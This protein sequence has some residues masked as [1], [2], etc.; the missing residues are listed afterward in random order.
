M[1]SFPWNALRH[2]LLEIAYLQYNQARKKLKYFAKMSHTKRR[3]IYIKCHLER[4]RYPLEKHETS[5]SYCN[6]E[7]KMDYIADGSRAY[8]NGLGKC[9]LS[10]HRLC[11][12]LMFVVSELS[13]SNWRICRYD[14]Q[15][16]R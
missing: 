10:H 4:Q 9:F 8:T 11:F 12:L 14:D 2:Q 5:S 7:N 15:F 13:P 3:C 16:T 6:T 1:P